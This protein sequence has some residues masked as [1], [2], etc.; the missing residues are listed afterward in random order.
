MT[1]LWKGCIALLLLWG[2]ATF[3]WATDA[4]SDALPDGGSS[5]NELSEARAF[6]EY[7]GAPSPPVVLLGIVM[8]VDEREGSLVLGH[9]DGSRS[10]LNTDRG[11]LRNIQVGDLVK[12]AAEGSTVRTLE[13]LD[14]YSLQA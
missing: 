10:T 4:L 2:M 7:D 13:P 9:G 1:T 14:H 12:V 3:G 5:S 8:A 6:V 11:L